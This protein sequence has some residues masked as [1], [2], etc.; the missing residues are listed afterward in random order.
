[1][2]E[3]WTPPKQAGGLLHNSFPWGQDEATPGQG[4]GHRLQSSSF[5][6]LP[7]ILRTGSRQMKG[8]SILMA[9]PYSDKHHATVSWQM[10]RVCPASRFPC[11]MRCTPLFPAS[12]IHFEHNPSN[13]LHPSPSQ[14]QQTAQGSPDLSQESLASRTSNNTVITRHIALAAGKPHIK[15]LLADPTCPEPHQGTTST[16]EKLFIHLALTQRLEG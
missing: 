12:R 7:S 11:T 9:P 13:Q 2:V 10:N 6:A 5:L 15:N 8:R 4:P 16:L 1:M 3:A 14:G